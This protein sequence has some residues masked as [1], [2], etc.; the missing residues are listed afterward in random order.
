MDDDGGNSR[1][2]GDR[3]K[4]LVRIFVDLSA[5]DSIKPLGLFRV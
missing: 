3:Y 2:S 5:G 1:D 4:R